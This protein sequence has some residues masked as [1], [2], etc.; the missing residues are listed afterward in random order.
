MYCEQYNMTHI[1]AYM[2]NYEMLYARSLLT[3][4]HEDIDFEL[5]LI[6]TL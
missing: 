6:A 1:S 3:Y 4:E 5:F 2:N